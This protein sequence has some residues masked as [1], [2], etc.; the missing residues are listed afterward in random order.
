VLPLISVPPGASVGPNLSKNIQKIVNLTTLLGP[1]ATC[2]L[3]GASYSASHKQPTGGCQMKE[4][5]SMRH[6]IM[7]MEAVSMR[8]MIMMVVVA[9]VMAAIMLATGMPAY[10]GGGEWNG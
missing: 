3:C 10:A 5:I 2:Q 9:L 6:M 4:V 7:L 8:H 1:P